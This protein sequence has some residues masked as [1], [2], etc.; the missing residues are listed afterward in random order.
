[1]PFTSL[2]LL[3]LRR[4]RLMAALAAT[5]ITGF[6]AVPGAVAPALAADDEEVEDTADTKFLKNMLYNLGLRQ[7][8]DV[9]RG[10]DYHERSPLVVP[11]SVDLPAPQDATSVAAKNPAWPKDPDVTRTRKTKRKILNT[12]EAEIEDQRQLRP[13]E[14]RG[15][16]GGRSAS[17]GSA[18]SSETA[19]SRDNQFL[20]SKLGFGG[21]NLDTLFSKEGKVVQFTQE[22][23]RERLTDP[24]AGL[25]TPSP[26]YQYGSKGTLEPAKNAGREDLIKGDAP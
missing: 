9:E 21:F 19:E 22:P 1:M 4:A 24:P 23:P 18:G 17:T 20:P 15:T 13:D 8:G 25:R 14:L 12:T 26:K 3:D 2:N 6:V 11:P 5:L 16:R 7:D 10:I